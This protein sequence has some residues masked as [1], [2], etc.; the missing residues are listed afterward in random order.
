MADCHHDGHGDERCGTA[1]WRR[2][3]WRDDGA[4]AV[5]AGSAGSTT[6]QSNGLR[7]INRLIP[8]R[9]GGYDVDR[10]TGQFLDPPQVVPAAF[11]AVLRVAW[12][13][14]VD[15][16]HPACLRKRPTVREAIDH[17][18]SPESASHPFRS[19]RRFVWSRRPSSTSSLV[20]HSPD[21]LLF[22]MERRSATASNQPQRRGRPVVAPN[23][24]PDRG[25]VR[26]HIIEQL[27]RKRPCADARCIRLDDAQNVV[28]MAG[29]DAGSRA[30]G[31]GHRVRGRDKR[32]RAVVDVEESTLRAFEQNALA[33]VS[34]APAAP[35]LRQVIGATV[36]AACSASSSVGRNRPS[37][38]EIV[39]S[40][41][42]CGNPGLRRVWRQS[43]HA[44]TDPRP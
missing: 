41:G 13:P 20:T 27:R 24:L 3:W 12:R 16:C 19:R 10:N 37:R 43:F 5:F 29:P 2:W 39:L 33:L 32:I 9:S 17:T 22:T 8:I 42:S 25:Q 18:G 4:F 36:S 7:L 23:S 30:R 28:E 11:A 35:A 34:Q 44:R 38:A 14:T 26:A 1:G 6:D 21:T 31:R 40:A 15:C